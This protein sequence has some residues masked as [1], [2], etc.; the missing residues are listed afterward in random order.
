M[1]SDARKRKMQAYEQI[2]CKPN[3]PYKRELVTARFVTHLCMV[4]HSE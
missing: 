2:H 1:A 4:N 3:F